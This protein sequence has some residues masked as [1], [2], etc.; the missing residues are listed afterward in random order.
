M[1]LLQKVWKFDS[2][3]NNQDVNTSEI[4]HLDNS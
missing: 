2:V 3:E 4:A 1:L